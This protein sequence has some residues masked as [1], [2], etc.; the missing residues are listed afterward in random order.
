MP[1]YVSL[2]RQGLLE[3]ELKIKIVSW[4]SYILLGKQWI[5]NDAVENIDCI[6]Q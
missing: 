1:N 3:E 2:S 5:V 4:K 6:L